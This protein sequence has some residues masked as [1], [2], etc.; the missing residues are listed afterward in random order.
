MFGTS[1]MLALLGAICALAQSE[2]PSGPIS[3]LAVNTTR[4]RLRAGESVKIDA[5]P[6]TLDFVLHAKARRVE[7][8]GKEKRGIVVGPN[9]AR[10][11][12]LL[13]VSLA[14][15]PGEYT[16][17]LSATA[18]AGERRDAT[19]SI[20]VDAL[21]AVPSNATQPPVIL[22]NGWQ[23]LTCSPS[24]AS[25]TFGNLADYLTQYDSVPVVYWFDNCAVCLDCSIEELGSDLAQT[26]NS[27][28]YTNGTPVPQV[29]LIAHSMGGLIVRSY[30]AGKQTTTGAFSP[31][32]A[33]KIRKAIFVATPHFGAM[34]ADFKLAD[35]LFAVG[36][37]TNELKPASQFVW[38]LGMWNQF[39]DD[40]RGVDAVALIGNA[41]PSGQSDGV[42]DSTSASLDFTMPGRTRVVNYCHIP[43]SLFDGLAGSYLSCYAPGIADVEDTSHPLYEIASSFLMNGTGWQSVGSPPPQ[44]A[45]L[46]RY[47][48]MVVADVS[49]ENQ[50]I[51]PSAVSW[52]NINLSEGG[53]SQLYYSDFAPGSGTFDFGSSTCG[54]WTE[55]PGVYSAVRCKFS[56][57]IYWVG[58]LLSGTGKVVQAGGTITI[59]GNGFGTQCS[60]C[61]VTAANPNAT[62][63][64]VLSW[65]NTTITA[66]LPASFGIGVATIGV[67]TASGFDAINIMAA[68]ASVIAVA[69]RSL[70]FAYAVGG[71]I[72][73][74]Q[75]LQVTNSGGGTLSWSAT[76]SAS[77]LSV[78]SPSGTAPSTLS[79]LVSPTGLGAGTHTGSV[80]VLAAG[81]S[82]SPVSVTVTLTVAPAPV[83]L[84]VSP[85][86]LTF[87]YTVGGA[88][89]ATQGILILNTGGGTLSWI[90][91]ASAAWVGLSSAS[92]TAPVVMSVSANPATLPAGSYSATVLITAAGATGSPASVSVTFVVQ[93]PQPTVNITAVSNGASFQ[94]GFASATWVSVLGTNLSQ[95]IRTWQNSD[96]INGL[97]PTSLSGVSVTINGLAAYVSYISPTQINAMAPDDATV[98]AVQVQVT[99]AQGKSNSF[100]AEKEQFAPGFFTIG[101][102]YAAALHAD[103]TLVGKPGLI[104]GVTSTPAQPGETI[105]IYGTGFGPTNPPLPCAQL[106]TTPADL[107][108]SVQVTLGGVA[109]PVAYSGMVGSGLYQF[110]VTV[111]N[112]PNGDAAVVAQ[113]GGVQTQTGVLIT[114]QQ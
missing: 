105:L 98:G 55:T 89:P 47:G 24:P 88:A 45:Y 82:N 76:T 84:A 87:N 61:G 51:V 52:G 74:A 5:P 91:S 14:M 26:V 29:D 49:S 3:P 108:T 95:T 114:I 83:S 37:Q 41:G 60:T 113:I 67:T 34:A 72:P 19:L 71:T 106:I 35:I 11:Q 70:Q 75:T 107:A 13:A 99:T 43:P 78:A 100:T 79:V 58:P 69:P 30:L 109:A 97:L 7:I 103:Y 77:W 63:L 65:N 66:F 48:G 18:E 23:G 53:A 68:P 102:S 80:Q 22:L 50:Y 90:A 25:G 93:T 56:P 86:A 85:Q 59:S 112:V 44:D 111:P 36:T 9:R 33:P 81:A 104:A 20:T 73:A 17:T 32:S 28:Q 39:G 110:N 62:A 12:I 38:D 6:E 4:Y 96:F 101:A 1:A 27:I 2:S 94:S 10:D 15:K 54:L 42:V 21:A 40:L 16:L 92:G 8:A 64:Q 57:S 31:P 46:S